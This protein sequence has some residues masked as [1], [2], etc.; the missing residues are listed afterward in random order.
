[1]RRPKRSQIRFAGVREPAVLLAARVVGH[2]ET[3]VWRH[4]AMFPPRLDDLAATPGLRFVARDSAPQ[5]QYLARIAPSETTTTPMPNR[6]STPGSPR[7][8]RPRDAGDPRRA[9]SRDPSR[10]AGITEIGLPAP[11]TG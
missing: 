9:G 5:N 1:M 8:R 3:K 4:V 11:T 7:S 2:F 10:L 6:Y